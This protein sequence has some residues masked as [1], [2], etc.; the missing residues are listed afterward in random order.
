MPGPST[1]HFLP[2]MRVS[3]VRQMEGQSL[4]NMELLT[5][6]A[7]GKPLNISPEPVSLQGSM[8][9]WLLKGWKLGGSQLFPVVIP[10]ECPGAESIR[11]YN[12]EAGNRVGCL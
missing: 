8:S 1:L 9:E 10:P 12:K 4:P 7:D 11:G 2:W 5:G 6:V 3:V